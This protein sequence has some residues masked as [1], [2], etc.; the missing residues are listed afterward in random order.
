MI[1][2]KVLKNG[3][4]II[5]K[6][7]KNKVVCIA[8]AVRHGGRNEFSKDKGISHFIEHMLYKGTMTRNSKQIS[9]EIEKNGGELNGFTSE[10]LTAFWCKMPSKHL[11]VAL[12]VLTDMVKNPLF[13]SME[14]EK[15]RQVIFE[16]MKLYKDN[17][18]MYVMDK[19]KSLLYKGD[20]SIPIIGT[21]E[22]MN[23]NTREKMINFFKK[24]Y[25][26]ENIILCVVGD[27]NFFEICD[28]I[29]KNFKK[30][31]NKARIDFPKIILQNGEEI[32]KRKGIDQAN[33]V[34]AY[35]SPLPDENNFYAAHVLNILMSG[36]M[37]SR[38]FSEIREK[39]NLAYA[40]KGFIE[41]EGDF[42]YSGVYVGTTPDKILEVK[43]LILEEFKKVHKELNEKELGDV[44][45]Q[46][47][48]NYLISQEDSFNV[49]AMLLTQEIR[50]DVREIEKYI[51]KIKLVELNDVKKL[52][53]I[54]KYS[55]FA[56]IPE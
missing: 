55:F 56:L 10:Q 17:P 29:E 49:L 52:A 11:N 24:I 35:H 4:T 7:R 5:F 39:R 34:F 8:F 38:L 22:S 42:S 51:D 6:E 41:S 50:G 53:N 25:V 30:S 15:E 23:S 2:R 16:E 18:S 40:V 31:K 9:M 36:G 44:K 54:K 32:E 46:I 48:G 3:M 14:I 28:F 20:F 43:R 47:I 26:P 45:E 37:S 19:I 1:C 27:A 33:L 21:K 12:N 13:D